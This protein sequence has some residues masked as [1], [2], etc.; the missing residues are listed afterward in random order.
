MDF[1]A[2]V[3]SERKKRLQRREELI[4]MIA[5]LDAE[6]AEF[7][8]ALR[9]ARKLGGLADE[10]E[11]T[12]DQTPKSSDSAVVPYQKL[13]PQQVSLSDLALQILRDVSPRGL[14]ASE[15]RRIGLEKHRTD[16]KGTTLTV[17]MGRHKKAGRVRSR[18]R[19]WFYVLSP[20]KNSGA[21]ERTD[22]PAAI[23]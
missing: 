1:I 2:K 19:T 8:A 5:A 18:G 6:L 12:A 21:S 10:S 13:R 17:A 7:E 20:A 14:R 11:R 23:A 16:I 4:V 15:I 9:V 3:E 22:A